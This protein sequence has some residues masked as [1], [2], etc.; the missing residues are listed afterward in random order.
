MTDPVP[1]LMSVLV[2]AVAL[3]LTAAEP[4]ATR[5][6]SGQLRSCVDTPSQGGSW[7]PLDDHTILAWSGPR[8]FRI[9]TNVCPRLADP[10]PRLTTVVRGGNTIC[11]PHDVKLYVSDSADR[12][13]TPCF[14]QSITPMSLEDAKALERAHRR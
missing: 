12:R 5:G 13:G 10:L 14:V 7:T 9:T 3:T 11:S 8:A 1:R 6:E 2:A 4:P